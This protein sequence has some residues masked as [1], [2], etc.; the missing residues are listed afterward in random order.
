[1]NRRTH[2]VVPAAR[3]GWNVKRGGAH[4]ASCHRDMKIDA[5]HAGRIISRNQFS[6]LVIHNR[7]GKISCSHSHLKH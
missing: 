3:G 5:I 4:R 7:N 6:E 2:H 1:M